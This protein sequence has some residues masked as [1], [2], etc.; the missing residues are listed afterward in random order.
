[1]SRQDKMECNY[2]KKSG[3]S[4]LLTTYE[5]TPHFVRQLEELAMLEESKLFKFLRGKNV[6]KR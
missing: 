2:C 4:K 1:M 3:I 5:G 6:I